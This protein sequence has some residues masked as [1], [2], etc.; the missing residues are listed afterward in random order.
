MNNVA[1]RVYAVVVIVAA[2][3]GIN[4]LVQ[5]GL[6][7]PEVEMPSWTVH[8]APLELGN[9]RGHRT[10]LDPKIAAATGAD[11]IEDR[12]YR[13]E[14]GQVVTL[15]TAMFQKPAAGV[16]HSPGLCYNANGWKWRGETRENVQVSEDLTIPVNVTTW[17]KE[18]DTILV[19]YWYQLG[20]HILYDR[21]S[22][23]VARLA[24]RG[25]P[26]WPVMVKVMIQISVAD[27]NESK[28]VLLGF[29]ERYAAWLNQPEHRKYL[30]QWRSG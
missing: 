22:M 23:G 20:Q 3:Y 12:A 4:R 19:A 24:L 21:A 1:K 17:E 9:W 8:D 13:N 10:Q 30:D 7:P 25:M 6:E 5:A 2:I 29:V 16:R 28:A 27:P 26:K 15:H 11:L 14:I 18:S